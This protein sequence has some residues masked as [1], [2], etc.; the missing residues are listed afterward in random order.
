LSIIGSA[1]VRGPLTVEGPLT[2]AGNILVRGPFTAAQIG[3][4]PPDDPSLRVRKEENTF[5]GPLTVRG[6][7]TVYGDLEVRGPLTVDGT[8]AA[9]GSI[10]AE[11]PI[12]Q[13][14]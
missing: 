12:V 14:R 9:A 4:V 1:V 3:R 10:D 2:V 6:P 13:R 7:L 5:Y 8:A 11:G